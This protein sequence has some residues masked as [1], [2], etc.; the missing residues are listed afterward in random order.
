MQTGYQPTKRDISTIRKM[1]KA[2]QI[3]QPDEQCLACN[4]QGSCCAFAG[5]LR[6]PQSSKFGRSTHLNEAKSGIRR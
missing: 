6:D 2:S 5:N 3:S 1:S 4:P